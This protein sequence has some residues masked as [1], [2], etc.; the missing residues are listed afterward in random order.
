MY[1][2]SMMKSEDCEIVPRRQS[3]RE[4]LEQKRDRLNKELESVEVAIKKLDQNPEIENTID[5][6]ANAL[7]HIA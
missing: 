1:D 4:R 6:L 7:G 2:G 3:L 5:V